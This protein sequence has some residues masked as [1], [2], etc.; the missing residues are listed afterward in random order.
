[1]EKEGLPKDL[2][3]NERTIRE[4]EAREKQEPVKARSVD[5]LFAHHDDVYE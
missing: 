2:R 1:M 4:L 3:V 5:E